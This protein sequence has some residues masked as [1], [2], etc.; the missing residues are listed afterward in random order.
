MKKLVVC[1]FMIA[2]IC[3][4][5]S[6][7]TVVGK[8]GSFY[9]DFDNNPSTQQDTVTINV[10]DT[11]R[12]EWVE[13][14]HTITSG[15]NPNDPNA[16]VLFNNP[17]N[18]SNTSFE[19][20]FNTVGVFDYHCIPHWLSGHLGTIVVLPASTVIV[21]VENFRFDADDNNS[22]QLD[23]ITINE[24]DTVHWE[25]VEGVHT[26]TSGLGPGQFGAGTLFDQAISTSS[27]SFEYTFAVAGTYP[28]FCRPHFSD[29]MTGTVEVLAPS[30]TAEPEAG[31][32]IGGTLGIG[33]L[34]GALTFA[35]TSIARK[36]C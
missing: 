9:F 21:T 2:L 35:G 3:G 6:A 7:K 14:N 34:L 15:T 31:M 36:R 17:A 19:F 27:R 26:V 29:N 12:W 20:T 4:V 23:T 25:W 8:V 33:L 24:G 10:G 28:Y 1:V 16:G 11:V 13:G 18:T 5:A 32:P 22:T 30:A